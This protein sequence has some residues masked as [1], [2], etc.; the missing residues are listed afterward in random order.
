[1][2]S[3]VG[4]PSDLESSLDPVVG[5]A[6]GVL[7]ARI[8]RTLMALRDGPRS[9]ADLAQVAGTDE[10]TM[11]HLL[12]LLAGLQ[13]VRPEG[14]RYAASIPLLTKTDEPMVRGLLALS[15]EVMAAWLAAN[16]QPLQSAGRHAAPLMYPLQQVFTQLCTTSGIINRQLV[17]AGLLRPHAA[18]RSV[19]GF[20]LAIWSPTSAHR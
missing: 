6:L 13:Y 7:A 2:V 1:M 3:S 16:Y 4:L 11:K 14:D 19:Q 20:I 15:R 8:A 18:A 9:P 12:A 17:E 5:E 10:K